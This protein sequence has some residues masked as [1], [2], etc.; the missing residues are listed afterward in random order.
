MNTDDLDARNKVI[1]AL[2]RK[3]VMALLDLLQDGPRR[4][5]D[6]DVIQN[7]A[8]RSKA[9]KELQKIRLLEDEVIETNG[10]RTVGYRLSGEGKR[11][12]AVLRQI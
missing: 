4:F 11:I 3:N 2:G 8:Q 10:R 12:L 6:L 1:A 5:S 9:L 7:E